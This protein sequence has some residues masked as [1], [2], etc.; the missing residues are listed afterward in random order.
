MADCDLERI[1]AES[2]RQ[3]EPN[4]R[5]AAWG[6]ERENSGQGDVGGQPRFPDAR[7]WVAPNADDEFGWLVLGVVVW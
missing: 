1:K 3:N 4:F 2:S 5:P 6:V 7:K